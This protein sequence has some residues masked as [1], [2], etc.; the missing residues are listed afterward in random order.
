MLRWVL[1]SY[2]DRW[3]DII[4]LFEMFSIKHIPREEN[5]QANRLA[6]RALGYVVSQEVFWVA[7]VS[8]VEHRYAL[9]SKGKPMLENSDRLYDE[10]KLM[11]DNTNWL[12][13]KIGL[14]SGKT[15]LESGKTEPGSGK[16]KPESGKTEPEQGCEIGL[17][18][19][20]KPTSVERFKEESVTKKDEV[21]KGGSP[22]DEG[23]TKPT[24]EGGSVKC[25]DIIW[26]DWR[27]PLLECIGDPGKIMDKK[28]KRKA[29][30]YTSLDDDIYQRTIDSVLLKCLGKEQAK[31]AVWEVHDGIC[32]AH[33]S[34]HKM[35]WFFG[36]V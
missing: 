6:Q 21:E 29:L 3:L 27:L 17:R 7:S 23:K 10:E 33:Q 14:D 30:K 18:E 20:A 16:A 28:I 25:G 11:P 35:K 19:E 12:P 15:E 26:T 8:F 9:R 24:T 5:S 13:R 32:G 22:L 36:R 34:A 4:K 2:R 1:N 31:V